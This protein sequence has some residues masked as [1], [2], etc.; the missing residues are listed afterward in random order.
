MADI[1]F[2]YPQMQAAAKEI[3]QY[4]EEYRIAANALKEKIEANTTAWTGA[5]KNRFIAFID[6]AVYQYTSSSIPATM[7][8]LAQLL[9]QNAEQM[10]SADQELADSLPTEL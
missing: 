7:E 10:K 2:N 9:E 8:A 1:I 5:S 4:A 3:R 6:G